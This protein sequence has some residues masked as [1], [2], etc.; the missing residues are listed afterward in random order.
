MIVEYV[1][2]I[3]F[4]FRGICGKTFLLWL[5][6]LEKVFCEEANVIV[7]CNEDQITHFGATKNR[8]IDIV[9]LLFLVSMKREDTDLRWPTELSAI[10]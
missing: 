10:V 9:F 3:Q 5:L 7:F 1:V 6:E 8:T 2:E 4:N